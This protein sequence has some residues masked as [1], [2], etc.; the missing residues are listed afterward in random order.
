MGV[1][2]KIVFFF[3]QNGWLNI[4]VKTLLKWGDLGPIFG[5]TPI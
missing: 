3:T 4:M 1:E 5:S 2:P